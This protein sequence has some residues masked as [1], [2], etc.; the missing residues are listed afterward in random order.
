MPAISTLQNVARSSIATLSTISAGGENQF[1]RDVVAAVNNLNSV[2]A[3]LEKR[4]AS[5]TPPVDQPAGKRY[6]DST[7]SV[8]KG[9]K[10]ALGTPVTVLETDKAYAQSL[11]SGGTATFKL[12]GNLDVN[13]TQASGVGLGAGN[14]TMKYQMPGST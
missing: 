12:G 2:V 11:S 4:Y 3:D 14:F 13:T 8:W 9:Y 6:F 7:N 10:T 1:S 5:A